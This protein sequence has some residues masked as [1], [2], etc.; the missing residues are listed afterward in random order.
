MTTQQKIRLM[1]LNAMELYGR[2]PSENMVLIFETAFSE[3]DP[4]KTLRTIERWLMNEKVMFSPADIKQIVNP[5]P[6]TE[7]LAL[8]TAM[9]IKEA[10]TKFGWPNGNEARAYVGESGW[11]V[12]LRFG[13]WDYVCKN[14]G[15]ELPEGVFIA[16]C[17]D[18]LKTEINFGDIG[19][20]L[21][22]PV[23]EQ[24][25]V[26]LVSIGEIMKKLMPSSVKQ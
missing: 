2:N 14:L 4:D 9:R 25:K 16:Q 7:D 20:D 26:G 23:I 22:Q 3:L 1:I 15:I 5:E 21:E 24:R 19:Y 11:R 18:V 10:I 8:H 12:V 17:R 13:G 6:S